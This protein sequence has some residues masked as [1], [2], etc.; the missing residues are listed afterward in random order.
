M[1]RE[2]G[3]A[4]KFSPVM[5]VFNALEALLFIR[6]E[7]R[8][9]G[10][11]RLAFRSTKYTGA[12]NPRRLEA[13]AGQHAARS[14]ETNISLSL[15][16]F[17]KLFACSG[18]LY[19]KLLAGCYL[20]SFLSDEVALNLIWLSAAESHHQAAPASLVASVFSMLGY[21]RRQ[22]DEPADALSQSSTSQSPNLLRNLAMLALDVSITTISFFISSLFFVL[23]FVEPNLVTWIKA[24]CV[25]LLLIGAIV[26][27][28]KRIWR[29]GLTLRVAQD[30]SHGYCIFT[31]FRSC[32][33]KALSAVQVL[34]RWNHHLS[35]CTVPVLR[36]SQSAHTLS[37]LRS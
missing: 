37:A 11:W 19:T 4:L 34:Y 3:F 2:W 29:D 18:V 21:S 31:F 35:V 17:I 13:M 23:L 15:A 22:E 36:F 28:I 24:I 8:E 30:L 12:T 5:C 20:G 27:A 10:W 6:V 1:P 33:A 26:A 7:R 16:S 14:L 9:P 25:L 32:L